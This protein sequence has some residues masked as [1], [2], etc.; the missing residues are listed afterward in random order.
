[1]LYA[2]GVGSSRTQKLLNGALLFE[3]PE[4]LRLVSDLGASAFGV[5]GLGVGNPL[6]VVFGRLPGDPPNCFWPL[7][8]KLSWWFLLLFSPFWGCP[9]AMITPSGVGRGIAIPREV[10]RLKPNGFGRNADPCGY[11]DRYYIYQY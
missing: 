10:E 6:K 3:V 11:K 2:T 7:W 8:P 9:V 1:M 5:D 4:S